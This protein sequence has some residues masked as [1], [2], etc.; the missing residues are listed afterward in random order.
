MNNLDS[1]TK[2]E[3]HKMVV[4]AIVTFSTLIFYAYK[5]DGYVEMAIVFICGV[6]L[7]LYVT[8]KKVQDLLHSCRWL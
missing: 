1:H 6:V 8:N 5:F 4:I 2:K 7:L 3:I